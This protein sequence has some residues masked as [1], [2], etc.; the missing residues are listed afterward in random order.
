MP[1]V[2]VLMPVYNAERYIDSAVRS[3]LQQSFQ[4]VQLLIIDDASSDQSLEVVQHF[5]DSRIRLEQ[6]ERN[7]GLAAT[8]NR[9]LQLADCEYLVRMDADDRSLP[10]RLELQVGFMDSCPEI[11]VSGTWMRL[12]GSWKSMGTCVSTITSGCATVTTQRSSST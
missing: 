9:G 6:N 2:V 5:R 4:D 11:G 8:L 7:L 10:R 1:R 3:I 12:F